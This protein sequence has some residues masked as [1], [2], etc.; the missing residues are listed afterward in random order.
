MQV[1]A[2]GSLSALAAGL[3]AGHD[4]LP[5]RSQRKH[6]RVAAGGMGPNTL[7]ASFPALT[8]R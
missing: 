1:S 8:C 7:L 2:I 6:V 5:S 4:V 3:V